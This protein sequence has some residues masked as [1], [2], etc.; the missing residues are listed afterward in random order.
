MINCWIVMTNI[1]TPTYLS[2]IVNGG[3]YPWE[4]ILHDSVEE[5][6]ILRSQF[7]HVHVFHGQQ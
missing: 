2:I 3:I 1:V 4:Q 7:G 5:Q 6:Q